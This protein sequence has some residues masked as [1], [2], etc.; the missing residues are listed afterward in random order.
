MHYQHFKAL[1]FL[2]SMSLLISLL[3]A[4][5]GGSGKPVRYYLIDPVVYDSHGKNTSGKTLSGDI[6]PLSIKVMDL[7]IPQYLERFQIAT[8]ASEG[9]LAF[10]DY[11]QWG[12]NLRKN[13]M[14]TLGRNLSQLLN[15]LD[16]GTPLNRSASTPDY[17][18]QVSIEQF[19]LD[20]DNR[21]KLIARWQ[22]SD[23]QS[24]QPLGVFAANLQG[25][26]PIQAGDY[27]QMIQ[28]MRTL[29]GKLGKE[30]AAS[31]LA[32]EK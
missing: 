22:L 30:I 12:E 4:C 16:V 8:R 13:L 11:H 21:V 18:L 25:D 31:I 5:A 15:T 27:D 32:R 29:Y 28:V 2:L 19:E 20:V 14:R 3:G 26:A 7:N 9:R 10:S 1:S 23:A 24:L 17:Q 6:K